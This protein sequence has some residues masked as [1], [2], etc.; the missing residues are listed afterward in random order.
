MKRLLG[1]LIATAGLLGTV[2]AADASTPELRR[3]AAQVKARLGGTTIVVSGIPHPSTEAFQAM[4][5]DFT[6]LTGIKVEWDLIETGRVQSKQFL[7][8]TAKTGR[9]DVYMFKGTSVVEYFAKGVLL[10]LAPYLKGEWTPRGYDYDD[11]LPAARE[12]LGTAG[13][14]VIGVPTASESFFLAYRK[15]LFQKHGKPAPDT[16]EQL[17]DLARFFK[18]REP[19]LAG[20]VMRAQTGRSL[21][22]AWSL[23]THQFCG[24]MVDQRT[25]EVTL[26]K[27]ETVRSLKYL[28]DLLRA[29]PIG[30]ENYSWEEATSTFM[31]GRAALWFEA[32]ALQP[33]LEDPK[34]STIVGKVGYAPPPKGPCGRF[35]AIAGWSMGIPVHAP[36]KE[37]AWAFIAYMTAR[38]TA[39]AYAD[40]GGVVSRLSTL[41]DPRY[42]GRHPEFV[43]ALKGAYEAAASLT[44]AGEKWVPPT[45]VATRFHERI[46]AQA[47]LALIG[48]LTPEE[49][50]KA[51]ARE[52]R[53][54]L[55]KATV[56]EQ[57]AGKP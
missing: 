2:T 35:G 17:L 26:E 14:T 28:L 7:D 6:E 36:H 56:K 29:G 5:P 21:A 51:A 45:D 9:Y 19:G 54:I 20:V 11:L 15:D 33:W 38:D 37:A 39:L 10:P 3:W 1:L 57:P 50:V 46:G 30:I 52:A 43:K 13:G 27:P 41:D 16:T 25:W 55:A 22:L 53:E 32:T 12:A 8:H 48:K 34:K 42:A 31:A 18:D 47:G 44:A 40:K 23:L 24:S 49:A 4:A